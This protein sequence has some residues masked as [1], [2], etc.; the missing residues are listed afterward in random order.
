MAGYKGPVLPARSHV[1]LYTHELVCHLFRLQ[2]LLHVLLDSVT[3][4]HREGDPVT[5][6]APFLTWLPILFLT[7]VPFFCFAL[8]P[9]HFNIGHLCDRLQLWA[10]D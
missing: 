9:V 2:F 4:L 8:G 10:C 6:P 3:H 5:L 7:F 1:P